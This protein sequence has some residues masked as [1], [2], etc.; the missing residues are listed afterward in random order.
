MIY[1]LKQNEDFRP[2]IKDGVEFGKKTK[3][4]LCRNFIDIV[5]TVKV[6]DEDVEKVVESKEDLCFTVD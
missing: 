6:N 1:L 5:K 4:K 3:Q 2:F